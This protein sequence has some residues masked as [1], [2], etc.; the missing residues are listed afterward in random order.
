MVLFVV[1]TASVAA[2]P[3]AGGLH[4]QGWLVGERLAQAPAALGP[5]SAREAELERELYDTTARLARL[6]RGWPA[7]AVVG[8][9]VGFAAAPMFLLGALLLPFSVVAAAAASWAY[10]LMAVGLA[11]LA[12]GVVSAVFG[13]QSATEAERE[14]VDLETRGAQLRLEL[15]GLRGRWGPPR[16]AA[17]PSSPGVALP[18]PALLLARLSF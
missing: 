15:D 16:P 11:G 14:R 17:P 1:L 18:E 6:P 9:V 2:L 7:L 3:S 5:S 8:A 12:L 4:A 10:G 13:H